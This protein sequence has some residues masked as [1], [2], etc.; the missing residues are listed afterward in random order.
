[1]KKE[2]H[3]NSLRFKLIYFHNLYFIRFYRILVFCSLYLFLACNLQA[4]ENLILSDL[5][6]VGLKKTKRETLVNILNSKVGQNIRLATI[7]EDIQAIRNRPGIATVDYALDTL[8]NKL[9]IEIHLEE[10]R[11][12]LPLLNFGGI[13]ENIW[14]GIGAVDHNFRG[15]GDLLLV[16]YQN[17]D[18]RHSGQVFYRKPRLGTSPWGFSINANKWSTVEPLFFAEGTVSYL[19]DNLGLGATVIYNL[20]G[21]RQIE[22]GATFFNEVYAQAENQILENPP[23]PDNL[24]LNKF[25]TKFIY[26]RDQLNYSSFHLKG[27]DLSINL[28]NVYNFY[29]QSF[30]NSALFQARYFHRPR[31]MMNIA[32]RFKFAISTNSASPFA[33][34]VADS[35]INLRGIGNRI[36]R[37]TAQAVINLEWR[38]T[39]FEKHSFGSQLVLF[40]DTGTWRV[41]G[42]NLKNLLQ[43]NQ[44]RQFLGIGFRLI[45]HKVFGATIRVD[46]GVDI[47][48]LNQ[49]GWVLGLGQYF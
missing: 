39:I 40:S 10:R 3:I 2:K 19:Y 13:R 31:P 49:R 42:G 23:G 38:Q 36:D 14:F 29:D 9:K 16:L 32:S 48:N 28:Q 46:Y 5:Q 12:L 22:L 8:D 21:K 20:P 24:S 17:N 4:Q 18:Q 27:Y 26:N 7:E 30:F 37:G 11:T 41:P 1:M 34:F 47:F 44:L 25:L 43:R 45:Y 33:P 15:L 6:F 35:H